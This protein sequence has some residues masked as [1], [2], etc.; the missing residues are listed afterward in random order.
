MTGFTV[1]V[2]NDG[3][4]FSTGQ[5]LYI[6]DS[7]CQDTINIDGNLGFILKVTTKNLNV[8]NVHVMER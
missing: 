2:S 4:H 3:R 8:D 7:I 5:P 6:L 1:S